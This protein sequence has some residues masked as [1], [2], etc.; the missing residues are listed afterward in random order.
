LSAA[1]FSPLSDEDWAWLQNQLEAAPLFVEAFAPDEA[2]RPVTLRSLDRAFAAWLGR[3]TRDGDEINGTI[4]VVGLRF[5]QFLVDEAGFEWVVAE[6]ER[7]AELA[8]RAL[9]GRGDVLVYPAN[10]VAKRWKRRESNFL[11]AAFGAI[12]E[13]TGWIDA[14]QR[15]APRRPWWRFW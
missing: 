4:N 2:G 6:D 3:G 12:R 13:Q 1:K 15:D 9:P 10:F 5:G 14:A 7:G 8:I 11:V